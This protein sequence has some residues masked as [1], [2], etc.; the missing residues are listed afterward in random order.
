MARKKLEAEAEEADEL[1]VIRT[2][3]ISETKKI[4]IEIHDFLEKIEGNDE[5]IVYKTPSF[6]VLGK[7]FKIVVIPQIDQQITIDIIG[8]RTTSEDV[9][10]Y[11]EYME[12]MEQILEVNPGKTLSHE[13]YRRFAKENGDVLKLEAKFTVTNRKPKD[14]DWER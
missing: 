7:E 13:W 14:E 1:F 5:T 3:R 2:E 9:M 11:M 12:Y 8:L 4:N 6:T 10:E